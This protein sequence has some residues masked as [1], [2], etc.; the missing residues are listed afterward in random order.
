MDS[1]TLLEDWAR[2]IILWR[3]GIWDMARTL[4]IPLSSVRSFDPPC[5]GN[6][7]GFLA[8]GPAYSHEAKTDMQT[9]TLPTSPSPILTP[10][11]P[12]NPV[13]AH[14]PIAPTTPPVLPGCLHLARLRPLPPHPAGPHPADLQ[15]HR[16]QRGRGWTEAQGTWRARWGWRCCSA[17]RLAFERL[18]GSLTDY[19]VHTMY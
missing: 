15:L 18:E 4:A 8:L 9:S 1:S 19:H 5:L 16:M 14:L 6:P 7:S 3:C 10:T 13:L 2:A 17:R 11:W 12:S